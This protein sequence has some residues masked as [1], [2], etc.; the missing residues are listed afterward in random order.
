MAPPLS[1]LIPDSPGVV[2]GAVSYSHGSDF[3]IAIGFGYSGSLARVYD[4][5]LPLTPLPPIHLDSS[6]SNASFSGTIC[7]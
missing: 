1:H 6:S 5:T 7:A 2:R 3:S 4:L